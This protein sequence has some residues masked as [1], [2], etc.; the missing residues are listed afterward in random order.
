MA[1]QID[2]ENSR[3]FDPVRGFHLESRFLRDGTQIF[4]MKGNQCV[5]TI[6]AYRDSRSITDEER[7]AHPEI[8]CEKVVIWHVP[9]PSGFFP[10]DDDPKRNAIDELV[11]EALK[12][13]QSVDGIGCYI[14]G[15]PYDALVDVRLRSKFSRNF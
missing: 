11:I 3:V 5:L 6:D 2:R 13:F 12:A 4:I 10:A 15:K 8:K 14:D 9:G 1:F 7:R